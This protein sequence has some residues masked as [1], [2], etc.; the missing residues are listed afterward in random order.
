MQEVPKDT[1][2]ARK[3]QQQARK[4]QDSKSVQPPHKKPEGEATPSQGD[5][6]KDIPN[7]QI[8]KIIAKRLL[9]SKNTVPHYFVRATAALDAATNL[10]KS[11][12]AQGTKASRPLF[13]LCSYLIAAGMKR[14]VKIVGWSM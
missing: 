4:Q 1:S 11:M 2:D 13:S 6:Y 10:R 7:S 9:E 5:L 12:K 14:I 8:R 3:E